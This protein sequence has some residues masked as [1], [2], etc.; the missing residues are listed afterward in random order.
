MTAQRSPDHYSCVCTRTCMV[1]ESTDGPSAGLIEKYCRHMF[2]ELIFAGIVED[3]TV[4][5]P[6][7]VSQTVCFR[8]S[9]ARPHHHN[10]RHAPLSR[11]ARP[12]SR[13]FLITRVI[14]SGINHPFQ[15]TDRE[16]EVKGGP[17][18]RI[19]HKD[20][21]NFLRENHPWSM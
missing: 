4:K 16:K 2:V 18:S 13:P 19:R 5:L 20:Y 10:T 9:I 15:K 6:S 7:C 8:T 17:S 1:S 14:S 12:L 21:A 11:L 3:D